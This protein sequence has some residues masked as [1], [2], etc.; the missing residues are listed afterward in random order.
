MSVPYARIRSNI[1]ERQA[2]NDTNY[3]QQDITCDRCQHSGAGNIVDSV[4]GW[5]HVKCLSCG[6]VSSWKEV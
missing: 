3:R 6:W 4:S 5:A 2:M 1:D